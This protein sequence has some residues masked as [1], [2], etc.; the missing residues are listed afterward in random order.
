MRRLAPAALLT[1]AM[2]VLGSYVYL[3]R[4]VVVQLQREAAQEGVMYANI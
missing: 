2:V 3:S 4:R 1:L